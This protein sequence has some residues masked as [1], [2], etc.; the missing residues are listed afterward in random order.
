[1]LVNAQADARRCDVTAGIVRPV[2]G[3]QSSKPGV[4]EGSTGHQH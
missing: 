2:I 3:M 4:V 1:M